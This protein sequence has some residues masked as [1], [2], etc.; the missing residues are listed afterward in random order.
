MTLPHVI[1]GES[2]ADSYDRREGNILLDLR[3]IQKVLVVV[4]S[5]HTTTQLVG[6]V[7]DRLSLMVELAW[8][9]NTSNRN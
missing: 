7:L 5:M 6:R 2:R 1:R 3:D 4:A 8:C 9:G